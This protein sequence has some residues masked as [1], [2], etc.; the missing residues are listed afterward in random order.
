M[1]SKSLVLVR[2]GCHQV[3]LAPCRCCLQI[4]FGRVFWRLTQKEF[5]VFSDCI[6]E[7]N[8]PEGFALNQAECGLALLALSSDRQAVLLSQIELRA[9]KKLLE[10]G[11][12]ELARHQLQTSYQAGAL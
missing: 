2:R 6:A 5:K 12:I 1:P 10:L 9:L 3:A 7:L 11:E 8:T 4:R